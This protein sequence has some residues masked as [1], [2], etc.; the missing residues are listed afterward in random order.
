[1]MVITVYAQLFIQ[2]FYSKYLYHCKCKFVSS[3]YM[4]PLEDVLWSMLLHSQ[5][6]CRIGRIYCLHITPH[7]RAAIC[8]IYGHVDSDMQISLKKRNWTCI[9]SVS[10]LR[11]FCNRHVERLNGHVKRAYATWCL[12][13]KVSKKLEDVTLTY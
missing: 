3:M 2:T 4:D 1:M 11:I 12:V 9:I 6:W 5:C 13:P 7:V 8:S 10:S